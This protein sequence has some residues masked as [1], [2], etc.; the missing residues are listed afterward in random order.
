M[1]SSLIWSLVR[2]L[3]TALFGTDVSMSFNGLQNDLKKLDAA[4]K[5][6]PDGECELCRAH[7]PRVRHW[8]GDQELRLCPDC[9]RDLEDG[10]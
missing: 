9:V 5:K 3:D 7:G 10:R 4:I 8:I 1:I 2:Q 6:A